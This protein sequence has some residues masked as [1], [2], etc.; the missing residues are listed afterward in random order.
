MRNIILFLAGWMILIAPAPVFPQKKAPESKKPVT[1][2][3]YF[4]TSERCP[5]DQSIEEQ[6]RK[7]VRTEFSAAIKDG[8]LR[9]QV[10]NTGDPKFAA[11][12]A[13][14]DINAQ[15][16]YLVSFSGGKEV[17][18]DLTGFAFSNAQDNPGKFKMA[19]R[20]DIH[21]AIKGGR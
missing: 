17:K 12:V 5:I 11:T 4:H 18:K 21:A 7:L 14:F 9:F 2:L 3:F 15:A 20:D 19:L 8:L 16:L 6:T 1:E 13:R 10:I